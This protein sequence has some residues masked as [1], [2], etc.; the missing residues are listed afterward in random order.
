MHVGPEEKRGR[1]QR[2]PPGQAETVGREARRRGVRMLARRAL[3]RRIQTYMRYIPK[4]KMKMKNENENE[5]KPH[6]RLG[7]SCV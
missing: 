6:G 2:S 7:V 3:N 5:I 4:M 1:D